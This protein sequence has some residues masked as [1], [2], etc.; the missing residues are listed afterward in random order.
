[1]SEPEVIFQDEH[2]L[3]IN[4]PAGWVVNDAS[5][6]KHNLVIQNWIKN[7]FDFPIS[8]SVEFR[9][10]IVHR[11]DKETSGVLL[12][13]KDVESFTNLQIQFKERQVKKTYLA[14]LH[15]K[16]VPEEG[17]VEAQIGRLP[18]RRDRFGIVAGGRD[19]R[20]DY[21]VEKYLKDSSG[22]IYTL[23]K[24]FPMTGRTH[25]IR[26]HSKHLHNPIVSDE[27]YAGRKRNRADR[28]WCPRLFLHAYEIKFS[29]PIRGKL[30]KFQAPLHQDLETALNS[31]Q[32]I[33]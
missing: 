28:N 17:R 19:S 21:K 11:L 9:S 24:F 15:D 23:T 12:I 18:W 1:M 7:N 27:F 4:K 5:T 33:N 29:H 32:N 25:Q 10:G 30:L 6:V 16:L 31:L 8:K 20:T 14:L 13:A 3:V 26:V 22:H 2:L